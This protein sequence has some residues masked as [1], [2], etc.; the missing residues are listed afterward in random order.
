MTDLKPCPFCGC[1]VTLFI[2]M[3]GYHGAKDYYAI[4]HPDDTDC[5][6]DG[7]TTSSYSDK[8]ELIRDW[9]RRICE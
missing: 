3:Y 7:M 8:E 4:A 2:T 5:I 1:P 9:N 6:V